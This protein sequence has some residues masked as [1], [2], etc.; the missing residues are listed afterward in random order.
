MSSG[1]A[2]SCERN[3]AFAASGKTETGVESLPATFGSAQEEQSRM[4]HNPVVATPLGAIPPRSGGRSPV[5]TSRS[6]WSS[7]TTEANYVVARSGSS[8]PL[9]NRRW[10]A[11]VRAWAKSACRLPGGRITTASPR[12]RTVTRP[13]SSSP[14]RWRTAA[15]TDIC[16]FVET[17]NSVGEAIVNPSPLVIPQFTKYVDSGHAPD[18][19]PTSRRPS[20]RPSPPGRSSR[21]PRRSV[22]ADGDLLAVGHQAQDLRPRCPNLAHGHLLPVRKS[23]TALPS[24]VVS[25]AV[26]GCRRRS[27]PRTPARRRPSRRRTGPTSWP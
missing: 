14:H 4:S 13:P 2:V 19:C 3:R 20:P 17:R 10:S 25:P 18:P 6:K 16:P 27:G 8:R 5:R 22:T 12:S 7:T 1:S 21:R 9:T 24:P 11:A 23:F 15:G 26:P